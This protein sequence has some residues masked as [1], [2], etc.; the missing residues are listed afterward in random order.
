MTV[1]GKTENSIKKQLQGH[2]D[3][4]VGRPI[5]SCPHL[6]NTY[7]YT[8]IHTYIEHILHAMHYALYTLSLKPPKNLSVGTITVFFIK[9]RKMRH[10][11]ANS[12]VQ[13]HTTSGWQNRDVTKSSQI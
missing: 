2:P 10:R 13:D 11:Q 9:T 6:V 8:H 5:F 7:I 12:L 1:Y 3:S 4:E